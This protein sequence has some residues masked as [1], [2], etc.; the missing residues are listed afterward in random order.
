MAKILTSQERNDLLE[1]I[2]HDYKKL[3]EAPNAIDWP[4][5]QRDKEA[6]KRY[7]TC[8][9]Y[10]NVYL[11]ANPSA[12]ALREDSRGRLWIRRPEKT[13]ALEATQAL[14]RARGASRATDLWE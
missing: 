11:V 7:K 5:T 1:A 10:G 2:M 3:A 8:D 12:L 13:L 9:S 14:K 4:K 6:A